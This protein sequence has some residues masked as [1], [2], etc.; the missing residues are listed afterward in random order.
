MVMLKLDGS[1]HFRQRLV[2]STISGKAMQ[3]DNIRADDENPGL[4]DYEASLLRLFEKVTNGCKVEINETGTRLRY[5]PGFVHG[6]FDLEHDCGLS[7][8]IG[9]FLEPLCLISIFGKYPLS[10]RLYGITNDSTDVSV[11]TWRTVTCPLMRQLV[12]QEG[13]EGNF[14]LKIIKRGSVPNGGGEILF[15]VPM[16]KRKLPP[17]SLVEE[18]LVK[19]VRGI[20]FATKVSPQTT[21]RVVDGARGVLNNLL[22]DVYIFTDHMSGR[23]AGESPGYGVLLVAETNS[24]RML[25][26]EV[27]M[28]GDMQRDDQFIPEDVGKRA[29]YMLLEEVSKGGVVDTSHQALILLMCAFGPEEINEVRLGPLTPYTVKTLRHIKEFL[30]VQFN[31]RPENTSGT[32]FL[33]CIGAGVTNLSKRIQ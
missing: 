30:G 22:P 9:Y 13:V 32:I 2:L 8:G 7:R 3:I 31:I 25:G 6:G 4:R 29:S 33:S 11:D 18:G 5:R 20:A 21:N 27:A 16:M 24:G 17:V 12:G 28:A 26:A 10:I 14:E 1:Q 15:K 23:E 19:R